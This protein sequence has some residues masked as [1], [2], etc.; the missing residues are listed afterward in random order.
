M[1]VIEQRILIC[2]DSELIAIGLEFMVRQVPGL[3]VIGRAGNGLEA[4]SMVRELAPDLVLMDVSM[5]EMDGIEATRQIKIEYPNVKVLML[6]ASED[7]DGVSR[8]LAAG[9]DGYCVKTVLSEHLKVAIDTILLGAVWLAPEVATRIRGILSGTDSSHHATKPVTMRMQMDVLTAREN[10]ILQ[11]MATGLTNIDI[12][13]Q[14]FV[15]S[16]TVKTHV[17]HIFEKMAVK[18][19]TQAVT[20]A[21][22]RG[23][24]VAA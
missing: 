2:D 13:K 12:A 16:E 10:E 24:V 11:L 1:E 6:S 22:K 20:E 14:L 5:P 17:R 19:R 23:M 4:L 21:I 9:A 15:S 3:K 7:P 8:S 18:H